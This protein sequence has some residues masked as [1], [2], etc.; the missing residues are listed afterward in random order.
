MSHN[1]GMRFLALSIALLTSLPIVAAVPMTKLTVQVTASDTGKPVDRASVIVRFRKA[2]FK[3]KMKNMV[4]SW[5]TKTN[6]LGA[7]TLPE[8]PQ[9]EITVQ[10]IASN[11]QTFGD[12]YDLD[13]TAQTIAIKLNPPQQQ[14]SSHEK[15]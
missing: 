15:K 10:I 2:H 3:I 6:Q 1:W 4:T 9:G 11:F 12:V 5:E 13:Q 8:M 7:V 14:Y